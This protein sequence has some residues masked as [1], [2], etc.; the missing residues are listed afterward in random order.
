[1]CSAAA[2]DSTFKKGKKKMATVKT[3]RAA[4]YVE[5]TLNIHHHPQ[6]SSLRTQVNI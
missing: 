6:V 4:G 1:M 2:S 5:G 3:Q